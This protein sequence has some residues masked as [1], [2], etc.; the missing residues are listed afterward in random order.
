MVCAV[1]TSSFQTEDDALSLVSYHRESDIVYDEL[2]V[3]RAVFIGVSICNPGNGTDKK[4]DE[5]N[6]AKGKMIAEAKARGFKKANIAK[7]AALFATRGGLISEKLVEAL[8]DREVE[9]I[10]DD[11][12]SVIKGYNQMKARWEEKQFSAKYLEETPEELV[13]L[14]EKL[15]S[16]KEE[17]IERA[18]TVALIK[19]NE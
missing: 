19:T 3:P 7:S 13:K 18:V 4:G 17:D 14:G 12:E 6:E 10:K 1:S 9:H 5:W 8:L 15:A 16:M 2:E 11:P